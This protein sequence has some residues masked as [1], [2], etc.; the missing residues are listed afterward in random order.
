MSVWRYLATAAMKCSLATTNY[1]QGLALVDNPRPAD[2]SESG[3]GWSVT[4]VT[5]AMWHSV[6]RLISKQR[7]GDERGLLLPSDSAHFSS[8]AGEG[9]IDR[10]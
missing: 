6:S 1:G 8:P 9:S 10:L 5:P 4:A 2:A 7:M 3:D